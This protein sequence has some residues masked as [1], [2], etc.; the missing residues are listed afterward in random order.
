MS[1]KTAPSDLNSSAST[2]IN[3]ST[4]SPSST[5]QIKTKVLRSSSSSSPGNNTRISNSYSCVKPS[6]SKTRNNS[7][8]EKPPSENAKSIPTTSSTVASN[9]KSQKISADVSTSL[10]PSNDQNNE[11][12][13]ANTNGAFNISNQEQKLYDIKFMRTFSIY[14]ASY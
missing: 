6:V 14:I 7:G 13:S 8:H 3:K 10:S 12:S 5:A 9:V 4:S 11:L 1:Q 2:S